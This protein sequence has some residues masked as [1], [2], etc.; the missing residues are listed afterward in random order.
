MVFIL[1]I[2]FFDHSLPLPSPS[3]TVYHCV[4]SSPSLDPYLAS[5]PSPAQPGH[6]GGCHTVT[7]LRILLFLPFCPPTYQCPRQDHLISNPHHAQAVR[8]AGSL[9]LHHGH[10]NDAFMCPWL[11]LAALLRGG[12]LN[13]HHSIISL[14]LISGFSAP[15]RQITPQGKQRLGDEP[16]LNSSF[17]APIKT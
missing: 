7:S 2:H 5:F 13:P 16:S 8:L 11:F 1:V 9:V 14:A 15:G 12:A 17:P 3:E 10:A 6:G 4:S